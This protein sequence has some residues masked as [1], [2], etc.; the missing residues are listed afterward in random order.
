MCR[1]TTSASNTYNAGSCSLLVETL[2]QINW[3]VLPKLST[4]TF[5]QQPSVKADCQTKGRS[6]AIRS[7]AH[8]TPDFTHTPPVLLLL[9]LYSQK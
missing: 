9:S 7:G 2:D 4:V 8:I 5:G 6:A 1:N 3:F